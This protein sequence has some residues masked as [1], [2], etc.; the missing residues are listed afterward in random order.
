[1]RR[2][3]P[4][5]GAARRSAGAALL[6][7]M[8]ILGLVTTI[9]AGM[10]WQQQR[11]VEVEAADR[12]RSQAAWILTGALDWARLILRED[13]RSAGQRGA[14]YTSLGDPWATPLD[15]ARLS[16]FLA[17]DQSNNADGGPEAFISGAI[18]DAQAKFNLRGLVDAAGQPVPAQIAGL[19]RLA[20]IAG[21]PSDIAARLADLLGRALVPQ[22]ARQP[23]AP[24]LPERYADLAWFGID[25][26]TLQRLEPYV[27]LLPQPTQVDANTAPRE[28]LVAAIDGLD[29]GTAQRLVD[30]RQ[31]APFRSLAEIQAQ[32]PA[33]LKLDAGRI[34]VFSSWFEVS[35]RLR[36][37]DRV[38]EQRSLLQRLNGTVI[39]RR[40]ERH[41]L[42]AAVSR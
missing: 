1:M 7:A 40:Q 12:A 18:V 37:E 38:L 28:V 30:L 33:T 24:I 36:I 10:V 29:L 27:D 19:Q 4:G 34:G 41:S 9:A 5:R 22:A 2:R 13:L 42:S 25:A 17:A 23:G 14:L 21:A 16:S 31:R 6:L 11:A 32:L 3:R 39:V 20:D 8:I 35:G 26:A 15:E